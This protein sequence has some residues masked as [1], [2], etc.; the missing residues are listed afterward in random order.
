MNDIRGAVL[1]AVAGGAIAAVLVVWWLLSLV[2][3]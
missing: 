3:Q 1:L 2:T